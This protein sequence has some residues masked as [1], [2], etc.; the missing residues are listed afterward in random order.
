M[1]GGR[2]SAEQAIR[3]ELVVQG[4]LTHEQFAQAQHMRD[5]TGGTVVEHLVALGIDP[6]SLVLPLCTAAGM[7]PASAPKVRE[8]DPAASAGIAPALLS[9]FSIVPFEIGADGIVTVAYTDP[10]VIDA[11]ELKGLPAH[12]RAMAAWPDVRAGLATLLNID[13]AATVS[14]Q[15]AA[16]AGGLPA[17]VTLPMG[18]EAHLVVDDAPTAPV[19]KPPSMTDPHHDAPPSGLVVGTP[20]SAEGTDVFTGTHRTPAP[21]PALEPL[22][23]PPHSNAATVAQPGIGGPASGPDP[24]LTPAERVGGALLDEQPPPAAQ[25]AWGGQAQWAEGTAAG[26]HGPTG[27]P[28]DGMMGGDPS[29]IPTEPYLPSPSSSTE[30]R[31]TPTHL[32]TKELK[33][34]KAGTQLGDFRIERRLG[35]GGMAAVYLAQRGAQEVALKLMMP[36]LADDPTFISRFQREIAACLALDHPNIVGIRDHGQLEGLAHYLVSEFVDGGTILGLRRMQGQ[37]PAVLTAR[38]LA[39]VLAGL[40]YA[41]ER[42]VIHRDIKPANL[43]MSSARPPHGRGMVKLADFGIAKQTSDNTLTATGMLVGTPAY[44]S[45]EQALG[46][47][48]DHR[49]D[50]YAVGLVGYELITGANP[51]LHDNPAVVIMRVG[52]GAVPPVFQAAPTIPGALERVLDGL[53]AH[54]R[55]LRYPNAQAAIDDLQPLL[56][57]GDAIAPDLIG[58]A[59]D[60]P[61]EIQQRCVAAMVEA[62]QARAARLLEQGPSGAPA[63]SIA[64]YRACLLNPE[65]KQALER[66]EQVCARFQLDYGSLERDPHFVALAAEMEGQREPAPGLLRRAAE[67]AR[68]PQPVSA[69]GLPQAVPQAAPHR[70]G[71]AAAAASLVGVERRGRERRH[72]HRHLACRSHGPAE[73]RHPADDGGAQDRRFQGVRPRR[74]A[75]DDHADAVVVVELRPRGPDPAGRGHRGARLDRHGALVG[76]A[77][78]RAARGAHARGRRAALHSE[79]HPEVAAGRGSGPR[80]HGGR[81]V[82]AG[83]RR[84]HPAGRRG[85][86]RRQADRGH[87][88][89]ARAGR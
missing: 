3:D 30:S 46:L 53:L 10:L 24:T 52:E 34:L 61:L 86:H 64:L 87:H 38:I 13:D 40:G 84:A 71:G 88:A 48:I 29:I 78:H 41:H 45:P 28:F 55:E 80:P 44:M 6:R 36:H 14:V 7:L 39:D 37:V 5:Q 58:A 19:D 4:V 70:L 60:D 51:F 42:G 43:L 32:S 66:F 69:R 15:Q 17:A 63:A 8:P 62:E 82:A 77:R 67:R 76:Q 31:S 23:L 25:A 74:R 9:R 73:R 54:N 75:A 89:R 35:V 72:L 18:A 65:D 20:L 12:R 68:Q 2:I 21:A 26:I 1:Q 59:V 81:R 50:L 83:G 85:R 16:A 27:S 79:L 47:E 49:S 22:P 57:M 11:A 33:D 56:K